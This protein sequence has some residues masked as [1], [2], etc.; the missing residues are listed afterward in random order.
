[1]GHAV[2]HRDASGQ[3][4]L[5][6]VPSL[7]AALELVERLRNDGAEDV[8]VFK[9]VPF[10]V[11]TYYRVVALEDEPASDAGA[12]QV[13][14]PVA[15]APDPAAG[16]EPLPVEEPADGSFAAT[17]A[18]AVAPE[19]PPAPSEPP[20]GATVVAPPPSRSEE[21]PEPDH[22]RLRFNRN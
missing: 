2:H 3:P 6:D 15:A 5:T 10:E 7:E 1:M 16:E 8:R 11:R 21:Q 17:S 9:E 19:P 22:R 20:S 14:E 13:D 12:A 4:Q 18:E